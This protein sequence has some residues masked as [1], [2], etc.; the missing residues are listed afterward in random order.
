MVDDWLVMGLVQQTGWHWRN[1]R[2]FDGFDLLAINFR[3]FTRVE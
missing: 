2:G 3:G 1:L